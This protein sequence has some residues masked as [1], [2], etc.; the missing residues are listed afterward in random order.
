MH[1]VLKYCFV[2]YSVLCS[3]SAIEN[4]DDSKAVRKREFAEVQTK[5]Q[6]SRSR[7]CSRKKHLRFSIERNCAD[8]TKKL[9]FY[10]VERTC[11]TTKSRVEARKFLF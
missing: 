11:C 8:Q 9:Y 4:F 3:S 5:I 7:I 6:E 1:F 2:Q 10:E